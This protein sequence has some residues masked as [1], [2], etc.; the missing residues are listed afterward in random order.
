MG[1]RGKNT[2]GGPPAAK[3]A[4]GSP[5]KNHLLY[6]N[7]YGSTQEGVWVVCVGSPEEGAL[8]PLSGTKNDR[9][10]E[11]WYRYQRWYSVISSSGTKYQKN[12]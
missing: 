4:R 10:R 6:S 11:Y 7:Q 5:R 9:Y 1:A 3:R 2:K 8:K 12:D